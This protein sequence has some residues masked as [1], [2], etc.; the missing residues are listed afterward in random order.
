MDGWMCSSSSKKKESLAQ[1]TTR[2]GDII[3]ISCR[4]L[5][6]L[7]EKADAG[8]KGPEA[9]ADVLLLNRYT[10][11]VGTRLF[12]T[13]VLHHDLGNVISNKSSSSLSLERERQISFARFESQA[14]A[15]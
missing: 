11:C 8:R 4:R 6:L 12:V 14:R 1:V 5:N 9:T 7:K 3:T 15:K 13:T 10:S 2:C